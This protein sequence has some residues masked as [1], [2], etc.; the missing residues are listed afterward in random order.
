MHELTI[1]RHNPAIDP[2]LHIWGWEISLYLFLGGL[3]AGMMM[4][5]GFFLSR[6]RL[7]EATCT[8]A[9]V[10]LLSVVLLSIGMLAL[11]LDLSHKLYVWRMYATFKPAS[12]MSWG[13][14]ILLLVYPALIGAF[15]VRP[16]MYLT[17]RF[18][19]LRRW[20]AK[21]HT[22]PSRIRA[23]GILNMVLGA[24]LGIYTGI[25]L[26]G[27]GARPLWNSPILAP[28]FLIS[29]LSTAA[30]LVHLFARD[31]DESEMLAKADNTFLTAELV[32]VVL[33]IIGL[34]SST[35]VHIQAA[36][37]LLTGDYAPVFWVLVIGMG[38]I[39]PLIIQSLAVRHKVAHMPIAPIMVIIGGLILRFVIVEAGQVSHWTRAALLP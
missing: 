22:H 31:R 15:L 33:L 25:L 27:F 39:I 24:M 20:S 21:L 28:L 3:I 11:F 5:T 9:L 7:K 37:L 34:I 30:A 17:K 6:Q 4:I 16:P 1:T 2:T 14:W 38:I 18:A 35:K 19:A 8:C 29:G 36:Q 10:P 26:S 12:P 23:V 32:S 13:S